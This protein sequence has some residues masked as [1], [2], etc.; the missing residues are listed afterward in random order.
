MLDPN[1]L[2]G[3]PN[4]AVTAKSANKVQF[5]DAATLALK[6]EID[7]PGSTHELVRSADGAKVYGSIYGGG[8]FLVMNF[9]VVPLSRAAGRLPPVEV[10]AAGFVVHMLLVGLPIAL[11]A[12]LYLGPRRA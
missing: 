8:I 5:F 10:Y 12:R 1:N 4:L 6:D 2:P 9:V 11:I 7:M 3:G